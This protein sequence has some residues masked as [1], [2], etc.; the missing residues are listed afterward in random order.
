MEA[1][2]WPA[3]AKETAALADLDLTPADYYGILSRLISRPEAVEFDAQLIKRLW[4]I[5]DRRQFLRGVRAPVPGVF[6]F[7]AS[8]PD[9]TR[10]G[11]HRSQDAPAAAAPAIPTELC[12]IEL[13]AHPPAVMVARMEQRAAGRRRRR[14]GRWERA[15]RRSA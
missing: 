9:R 8:G 10:T 5:Q 6:E 14:I 11:N 1:R 13:L 2:P 15:Q 12:P 3:G 4:R 7:G